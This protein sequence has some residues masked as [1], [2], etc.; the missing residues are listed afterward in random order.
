MAEHIY[1]VT[2]INRHIKEMLENDKVLSGF[3]L[4]GEISNFVSHSSGHLYFTLKD[5]GGSVRC[6]MFRS[7]TGRVRFAPKNGDNVVAYGYISVYEKGGQYQL[8]VQELVED[9]IGDLYDKYEKLKKQLSEEGLFAEERKRSLPFFPKKIGIATSPTGAAIRDMITVIK[10]RMPSTQIILVP[11]LVQG[12]GSKESVVKALDTLYSMDVDLI[13]TGR[14]G[15]SIE[16]LWSFNEEMVVRKITESP[17]PVISAVGHETDYTLADFVADVRAATPSMAAE[18]A[19]PNRSEL[20]DKLWQKDRRL[21]QAM[22]QHLYRKQKQ[23]SEVLKRK[24]FVSPEKMWENKHLQLE[25]IREKLI[26]RMATT[27]NEKQ[28]TIAIFSAKL[29]LLSPLKTLSRG[30]ALPYSEKGHLLKD[31]SQAEI[32]E[33]IR[34]KL[35]KGQLLCQILEVNEDDKEKKF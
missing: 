4:K 15:G 5:E 9:G 6:V 19:V 3:W 8:Y 17:V 22:D 24:I 30:Y 14:G 23:L 26:Q 13:I 34:L 10:R 31:S 18:I 16:E 2:E 27:I 20:I 35:Y 33:I 28:K 7:R 12:T 29:D 1:G 21:K 25:N 32:D 11:A